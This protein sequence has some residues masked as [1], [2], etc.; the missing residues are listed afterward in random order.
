MGFIEALMALPAA[1]AIY[2]TY[3]IITDG[4]T[5]RTGLPAFRR[6]HPSLHSLEHREVIAFYDSHRPH[7]L[8][9]LEGCG[10]NGELPASLGISV[11]EL[12]RSLPWVPS[13]SSIFVVSEDGFS[14]AVLA[15]LSQ[16]PTARELYLISGRQDAALLT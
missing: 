5:A 3:L 9:H 16:L 13:D 4:R 15:R 2:A 11:R 6:K 14:P 10:G 12:E 1:I 7:V 8:F